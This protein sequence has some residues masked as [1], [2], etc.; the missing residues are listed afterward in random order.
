MLPIIQMN[1]NFWIGHLCICRL[2]KFCLRRQIKKLKIVKD[3]FFSESGKRKQK[4]MDV[5]NGGNL[6]SVGID[7]WKVSNFKNV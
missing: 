5:G 2:Q 1:K 4:R 7:Y 6:I 3:E